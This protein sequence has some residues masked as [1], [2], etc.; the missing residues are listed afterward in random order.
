MARADIEG[1]AK[2]VAALYEA[3]FGG[4]R[5]GRFTLTRD[6]IGDLMGVATVHDVSLERLREALLEDHDLCLIQRHHSRFG[7][8]AGRKV[9][10]WRKATKAAVDDQKP[11]VDRKTPPDFPEDDD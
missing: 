2:R 7:V 5:R 4:K 10:A 9:G 1:G 8:C 3:D 11:Q 6:Q